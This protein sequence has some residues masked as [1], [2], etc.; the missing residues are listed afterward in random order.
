MPL[1]PAALKMNL[2]HLVHERTKQTNPKVCP[3]A[4]PQDRPSVLGLQPGGRSPRAAPSRWWRCFSITAAC[5]PSSSGRLSVSRCLQNSLQQLQLTEPAGCQLRRT[6][7]AAHKV[8]EQAPASTI[9][10]PQQLHCCL[11]VRLVLAVLPARWRQRQGCGGVVRRVRCIHVSVCGELD[12]SAAWPGPSQVGEPSQ[13][14]A[15]PPLPH[16]CSHPDPTPKNIQ[17]SSNSSAHC[18]RAGGQ[19]LPRTTPT[20]SPPTLPTHLKPSRLQ[21]NTHTP[22]AAA[23]C[24]CPPTTIIIPLCFLCHPP[25]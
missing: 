21:S 18:R 23:L 6:A 15:K 3:T 16:T 13:E 22:V 19:P 20:P 14:S 2:L 5:Q 17:P 12:S 1:W 11:P 25:T 7:A 8:S 4:P 24:T 9:I 10:L